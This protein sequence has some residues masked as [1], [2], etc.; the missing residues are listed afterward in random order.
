MQPS[1]IL[2]V[3]LLRATQCLAPGTGGESR[4]PPSC[5]MT[6]MTVIQRR[7]L[8]KAA[9]AVNTQRASS[10][11]SDIFFLVLKHQDVAS[12]VEVDNQPWTAEPFPYQLTL[13][14][15]LS[16]QR[17]CSGL[18]RRR[19]LQLLDAAFV[20]DMRIVVHRGPVAVGIDGVV[21]HLPEE[22]ARWRDPWASPRTCDL[23]LVATNPL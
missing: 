8:V 13:P 15:L 23:F 17:R 20:D 5:A 4:P 3:A 14:R 18:H 12:S 21:L 7:R 6:V 22:M 11:L 2:V 10:S 19:A 1:F 9:N 16:D